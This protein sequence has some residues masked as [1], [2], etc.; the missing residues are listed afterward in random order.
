L[1]VG[2]T[3]PSRAESVVI[4]VIG[5]FG[6]AVEGAAR[7]A[8]ERSVADLVDRWAP[9]FIFTT[10]DNNYPAGSGATIDINIGQYYHDYIGPY[11]GVYGNG[12]LSNRFFPCLGNHDVATSNGAPYIAYF[13]LPGNERYYQYRHGPVELFA[14]NSNPD[15]DGNSSTSAQARWLQ[16]QLASSTAPWKLVYF[17]H[18]P[19]SAS[20]GG[21]G[22]PGMRWPFGAWGA[23]AVFAGHEHAYARIFTNN[24][25][26]FVN[27]VG[28]DD[29]ESG[30][31]SGGSVQ[32]RYNAD[33]GAMRLEATESNLVAHF[34]THTDLIIDSLVLGSP[35]STP[36]ILAPPVPQIVPR[37]RTVTFT[38]QAIGAAPLLY[39]W[40][41]NGV[42]LPGATNRVFIL[43]NV[44][45]ADE[46]DYAVRVTAAGT[47]VVTRPARLAVL[48]QPQITRQP[49]SRSTTGGAAV[50]FDVVALGAGPLRYQWMFNETEIPGATNVSLLLTN[51]HLEAMGDYRVRVTDDVGSTLS[52][53]ATLTVLARPIVTLHPV[54]QSAPVGGTAAFSVSAI[55]TLPM[56][57]SWRHNG[58]VITNLLLNAS[59]CFWTFHGLQLADAGNYAV[60]ITNIAGP[61][62]RLTNPATLSVL[63]DSDQDGM[64]DEWETAHGFDPQDAEDALLDADADGADNRAEYE[65]DTDPNS[66]DSLLRIDRIELLSD[67]TS[68]LQFP[69]ISNKTYRV[70]AREDAG[71]GKWEALADIVAN[72]TNRTVEV[73]DLSLAGHVSGRRFY[74]VVTPRP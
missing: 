72:P 28:G 30:G 57:Y 15:P 50:T 37:G 12:A 8:A 60:G 53:P 35:V 14:L 51:Y 41:V 64:P 49:Q 47:G 54:S 46:A 36:S 69:A 22:N 55:G 9:D 23:S 34:I 61:A 42:D 7:A 2:A 18:P 13:T 68:R 38:V 6:A 19:Y 33:Y 31:N 32:L 29:L 67:G 58:R 39:Q 3:S 48:R 44:Q 4:G 63:P 16:S 5:D 52:N 71:N 43:P 17:H 40:Q 65:A 62:N 27:G 59:T 70:E 25:H 45:F 56:N 21:P 73:I 66:S 26:Y 10:G 11:F 1:L 24:L 20:V 74:R